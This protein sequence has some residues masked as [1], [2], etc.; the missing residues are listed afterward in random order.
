VPEPN[1]EPDR[2]LLAGV[3]VLDFGAFYA[4]PYGSRLL[5]DLGADV[6]KF[7]PPV[8]DQL[9]GLDR[10]FGSAQA[11][12]RA[13]SLNTK[14]PDAR[15]AALQLAAWADV[16]QHNLRP[17]AAER[18]GLGYE[19]VR[20]VNPGV[21]YAY[22]PGW[23]S[24][25]PSIGRQ[26]FAPLVSGY[27]GVNFEV[28]GQFN[29]PLFPVGNED[30]GNGLVGAVGMLM[31]LLHRQRS[32][33]GQYLEH[34]RLNATMTHLAHIVRKADGTV[35]GAGRLDTLQFGI[36]ALDRLYETADGWLCVSA[37]EHHL[38]A[39]QKVLGIDLLG[40]PRYATAAARTEND[41]A[42]AGD[43]ADAIGGR[44]TEALLSELREA[45]VPAAVP[46]PK[47]DAAFL[48][49]EHNRET[50]RVGVSEHPQRGTI[51]ELARLVRVDRTGLVLH[52]RVPLLGEHTDEL[53]ESVGVPEKK[54]AELR[55][56]GVAR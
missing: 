54:I 8:G 2:P 17:G 56:R 47:N 33:E 55:E 5:A 49:D 28:A 36:G 32:G 34:P 16:V 29:P 12:K 31:G 35:L 27:V 9:R 1:P 15:E 23:G 26:S 10:P 44:P 22:S 13:I 20:A 25:G 14:N 53:L 40:D 18:M 39:L 41:L 19:D 43:L 11:N 50:G 45:G 52:R 7:E 37:A 38:G 3:K 4:G 6:I 21:V 48:K 24:T 51:R 42:L 30:P 46:V